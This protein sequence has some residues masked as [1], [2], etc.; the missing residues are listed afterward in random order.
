MPRNSKKAGNK[1]IGLFGGS[2]DP[3]H[4]AHIQLATAAKHQLGFDEI[5]VLID[6]TPRGKN[7][8]TS[9]EDR[10]EMMRLATQDHDFFIIDKLDI[11]TEG[12]TH[13]HKTLLELRDMYPNYKFSLIVGLDTMA[14]F[15]FWEDPKTFCEIVDFAVINRPS[16]KPEHMDEVRQNLGELSEKFNYRF[17]DFE[18]TGLSSTH[19]RAK[20]KDEKYIPDIHP[21]V[22][23]YVKTKKL[24]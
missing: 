19:I 11:Q 20:L 24:Y 21:D 3:V 1:K 23:R 18:E 17:I 9:Y 10:L 13:D 14:T 6:K 4:N 2:F 16:H 7:T 5:W 12:K 15:H 8:K 22:L